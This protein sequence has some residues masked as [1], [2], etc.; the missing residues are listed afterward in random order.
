MRVDEKVKYR[1]FQRMTT[2][3]SILFYQG[4]AVDFPTVG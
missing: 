1:P 4:G 3:E 2:K